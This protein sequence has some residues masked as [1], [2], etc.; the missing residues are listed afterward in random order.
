MSATVLIS[1]GEP[2]STQFRTEIT[3]LNRIDDES[4]QTL[5]DVIFNFLLASKQPDTVLEKLTELSAEIG[6]N[7]GALKSIVRSLLSLLKAAGS[8]GVTAKN[9]NQDLLELGLQ[10]EKANLIC[11]RWTANYVAICRSMVGQTFMINQL[12]DMEWKFGV[13]AASSEIK[14][15][16]N[17]FLQLKLVVNKG[18]DVM[19]DIYME[20]SLPQ[21]Y[22]FLHE[23]EKAKANLDLLT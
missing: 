11:E 10:E 3:A 21:F 2:P 12:V 16:G 9:I 7:F 15:V 17:S 22:T 6:V 4:F 1:T 14:K 8:R 18:N 5:I 23:M 19:E 20:L 13:T